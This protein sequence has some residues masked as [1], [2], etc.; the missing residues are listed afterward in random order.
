MIWYDTIWYDT[1]RYDMIW[2]DMIWYDMIWYDMIW[3]DDGDD[4]GDGDASHNGW[5]GAACDTF[6]HLLHL[7]RICDSGWG[8]GRCKGVA[9]SFVGVV[10]ASNLKQF[11]FLKP[12][13]MMKPL[14]TNQISMIER[15]WH[16][17][18]RGTRIW[19]FSGSSWTQWWVSS[20]LVAV[21]LGKRSKRLNKTL[22]IRAETEMLIESHHSSFNRLVT[23]HLQLVRKVRKHMYCI[24]RQISL[25]PRDNPMILASLKHVPWD[26][27]ASWIVPLEVEK[28]VK[29]CPKANP[30]KWAW[31]PCFAM[32]VSGSYPQSSFPKEQT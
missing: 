8:M 11:R 5:V 19:Q 3:Y 2:Y 9:K 30:A 29:L 15:V 21:A 12:K 26:L 17:N 22:M 32:N 18:S 1:I 31:I 25:R 13:R 28:S 7:R 14:F 6:C 24:Y 27:L 20:S 4:D 16:H 10:S 23:L